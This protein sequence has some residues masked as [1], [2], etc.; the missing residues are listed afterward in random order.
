MTTL[1]LDASVA[2]KWFL[3]ANSET[4]VAQALDVLDRYIQGPLRLMVP[5]LF[6]PELGNVLWKA[7]RRGLISRDSA[8]EA[9]RATRGQAFPTVP[10]A[11]LLED[12][13]TIAS[14]FDRTV[15]D[16]LYVALAVSINA[17]FVTA[18]ERLANAL[19]AHLPVKWLGAV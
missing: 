2:A 9:I 19:A 11:D 15:Y 1:V 5:D 13:L 18:D 16:S 17:N 12:A 7:A 3:P 8:E 10:S 6:W 4:L 14:T